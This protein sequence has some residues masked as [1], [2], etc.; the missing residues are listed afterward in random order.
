[1]ADDERSPE[2]LSAELSAYAREWFGSAES[3]TAA[4]LDAAPS[5]IIERFRAVALE[6]FEKLRP[7]PPERRPDESLADWV[8]REARH[9]ATVRDLEHE[10]SERAFRHAREYLAKQAAL[11]LR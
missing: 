7:P 4:A 9:A 8:V 3:R 6:E 1:M 11:G 10:L 5:V 2:A